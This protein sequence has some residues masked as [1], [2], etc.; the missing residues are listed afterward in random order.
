MLRSVLA[1]GHS[2]RSQTVGTIVCA[3]VGHIYTLHQAHSYLCTQSVATHETH[4]HTRAC[5]HT[6]AM[7]AHGFLLTHIPM[8]THVHS[9]TL[10]VSVYTC[11]HRHI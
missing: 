5:A 10:H 6:P 2:G 3:H 8:Y 7:D 1:T 9:H 11:G 4:M